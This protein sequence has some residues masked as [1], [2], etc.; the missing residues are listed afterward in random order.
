MAMDCPECGSEKVTK[1]GHA[2][3]WINRKIERVQKYRCNDCGRSF[4]ETVTQ[5]V[6]AGE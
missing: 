3:S 1:D 2:Q 5:P 6:K 4:R